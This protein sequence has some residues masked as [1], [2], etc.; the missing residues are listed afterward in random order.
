MTP[1]LKAKIEGSQV[2]W[3]HPRNAKNWLS[4]LSGKEVDVIVRKHKK[5][6]TVPQNRLLWLFYGVIADDTGNEINELYEFLKSH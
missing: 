5:M 3:K 1:I 6:R 2:V 4:K